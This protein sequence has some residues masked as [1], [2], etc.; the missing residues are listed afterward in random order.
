MNK[1]DEERLIGVRKILREWNK[2]LEEN[3]YVSGT[4]MS[5]GW[6]DDINK[7]ANG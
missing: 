3:G 5:N 1:T 4:G 6:Y 2:I 7:E